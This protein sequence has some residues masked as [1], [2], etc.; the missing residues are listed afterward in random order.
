M[1]LYQ[2]PDS[3]VWWATFTVNG[4]RR[5]FSTKRPLSDKKGAL[6]VLAEAYQKA[7]D[8]SQ[9][10]I[11]EEISLAE[12]FDLAIHRIRKNEATRK[13]YS[14]SKR[15]TLNLD[16]FARDGTYGQKGWFS[17]PS[18][19]KASELKDKH[20]H[21]LIKARET[22]GHRDG[23]INVLLRNLKLVVLGLPKQYAAN[24]DLEFPMR[25]HFEKQRFLTREEEQRVL[26]HL[27]ERRHLPS[28]QKAWELRVALIDT[29]MR[30]N[31]ALTLSWSKIVFTR[32]QI[33]VYRHKTK[34]RSVV[35]IS[36]R[37]RDLLR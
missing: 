30:K 9:F 37:V 33:E 2:R 14:L 17:L 7:L 15:Q 32:R 8:G 4:K 20:I 28:H 23:T 27:W 35:P 26:D 13:S 11:K 36:G 22:W 25:V 1:E 19:I 16:V 29:G 10:G 31:E 34:T 12:A 3:E 6:R 24:R 18:D 5:R 21:D